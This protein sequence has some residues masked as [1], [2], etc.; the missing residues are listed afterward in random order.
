MAKDYKIQPH[1][2][3]AEQAV[4]GCI[5][6]DNQAQIDVLAIMHESDFYSEAHAQIFKAMNKVYQKSIPVDFVTLTD[7]LEKDG[8]LEK[9]GGIDYIMTLTNT[10]PSAANFKH[11][12]DIV[13][14]DSI[15]RKLIRSGQ[16]IIEDAFENED[17][18]K[19]LQFAEQVIFDIAEKEGRSSLE[20]VGR[21]DGAVKKV[22]DKFGEIAKDPTVLKGIPTGFTDFDKITNGLQNSD[23][24]LL[25]A[26]PG[27][28]KTSFSMNILVHAATELNKKCA[29]FSLEMSKEQLMQRA[30]CSKAKVD[31]GK[32]L[33]G[34]MDAEEWK[35]IWAASKKL[36]QSGLYVDDSSMTTPADLLSKCRRLKMQDGL[37]LIMVDYIQLMTSARKA[38]NRQLEIS[39]ISRTLKIAAKELNVP[40]IVLSQLSRAV[41]SRQDHRPL[42]SD[43]RDSGAIEQDADIVLFIYNP[44]KYNDVPQED[45][46]GTVELIVAKHRNGGTGTV[47][48]RW[49]GQ[50]TTFVNIKD[51]VYLPKQAKVQAKDISEQPVD[52]ID[53]DVFDD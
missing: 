10:V 48:L 28:G 19:S 12:C 38:D 16:E 37:D 46:P 6:I 34:E 7:Q 17:K 45:E 41:E 21:S 20:H 3:E 26:R 23:L 31:M 24:I 49:I 30:V 15:R 40:I 5:L 42:L 43:L 1:N 32:A 27:V 13:K 39:D 14:A 29:I 11:Y 33:K 9:V 51:K 50:Y 35:R 53:I 18:D 47:K 8:M 4:L 36:E 25:A 22:I 2:L 44:E 52:N